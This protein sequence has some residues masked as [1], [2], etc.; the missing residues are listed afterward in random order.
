MIL[1]NIQVCNVKSELT[2]LQ[3]T[4]HTIKNCPAI[5]LFCNHLACEKVML[6]KRLT[7]ARLNVINVC[8]HCFALSFWFEDS[9]F[10]FLLFLSVYSTTLAFACC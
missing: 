4:I 7:T 9:P 1:P 3:I 2:E 10:I 5:K 6:H 8:T